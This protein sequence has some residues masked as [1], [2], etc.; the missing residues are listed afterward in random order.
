[1][2]LHSQLGKGS[3]QKRRRFCLGVGNWERVGT[4]KDRVV[5][6][7]EEL[8][9]RSRRRNLNSKPEASSQK[10]NRRN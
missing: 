5:L 3:I 4:V 7:T 9:K 2:S 6:E 8:A 10:L 1:M